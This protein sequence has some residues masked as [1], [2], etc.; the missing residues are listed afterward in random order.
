MKLTNNTN[1]SSSTYNKEL[2]NLKSQINALDQYVRDVDGKTD[3]LA[4]EDIS[5][6]NRINSNESSISSLSSVVETNKHEFD[7]KEAHNDQIH[8]TYDNILGIN[9]DGT[10]TTITS[11]EF[12]AINTSV[13]PKPVDIIKLNDKEGTYSPISF[14]RS[15]YNQI[16]NSIEPGFTTVFNSVV[17]PQFYNAIASGS[18][19]V[20]F[21]N[22]VLASFSG[23]QLYNTQSVS[24]PGFGSFELMFHNDGDLVTY[25]IYSKD[26]NYFEDS[27]LDIDYTI[28]YN[29]LFDGVKL[30]YQQDMTS[31]TNKLPSCDFIEIKDYC[32]INAHK[33]FTCS[34]F[35]FDSNT[36]TLE[37][38]NISYVK[39]ISIYKSKQ[40]VNDISLSSTLDGKLLNANLKYTNGYDNNKYTIPIDS[41]ELNKTGFTGIVLEGAGPQTNIRITRLGNEYTLSIL[42]SDIEPYLIYNLSFSGNVESILESNTLS[43]NG[44]S[45]SNDIIAKATETYPDDYKM[46]D[47][48]QRSISVMEAHID[49]LSNDT[50]ITF[51]DNVNT[52]IR[53]MYDDI[54]NIKTGTSPLIDYDLNAEEHTVSLGINDFPTITLSN[55]DGNAIK[56]NLPKSIINIAGLPTTISTTEPVYRIY[57]DVNIDK[58]PLSH[59]QTTVSTNGIT[60]VA[61]ALEG[62]TK[63]I[64]IKYGNNFT[65]I[66]IVSTGTTE[67]VWN[68]TNGTITLSSSV[69]EH[70][71][72]HVRFIYLVVNKQFN[73]EINLDVYCIYTG[74][75]KAYNITT[76]SNYLGDVIQTLTF[77]PTKENI[78]LTL[79]NQEPYLFVSI[80]GEIHKV[81]HSY[82][83]DNPPVS[84]WLFSGGDNPLMMYSAFVGNT[85]AIYPVDSRLFPNTY[86]VKIYKPGELIV[87]EDKNP[88]VSERTKDCYYYKQGNDWFTDRSFTNEIK[89][90]QGSD[91]NVVLYYPN[92]NKYLSDGACVAAKLG[93]NVSSDETILFN[94]V[95][96]TQ[97]TFGGGSPVN[98]VNVYSRSNNIPVILRRLD[99]IEIRLEKIEDTLARNLLY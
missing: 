62:E 51:K 33:D 16:F 53:S 21:N 4:S 7:T 96:N 64:Y 41:D 97:V 2:D 94:Y 88:D 24:I 14:R 31:I 57:K 23:E 92:T 99:D 18:I 47:A 45:L 19:Q 44:L 80:N 58:L 87:E 50:N 54:Q 15:Y 26:G 49:H 81:Y 68:T 76:D 95:S 63:S 83:Y 11:N 48:K 82:D 86:E 79:N 90:Y 27:K 89:L 71:E 40:Y 30:S 39:E 84:Y 56:A 77:E 17:N 74:D 12:K 36:N 70:A 52:S 98:V 43:G 78:E 20:A 8:N 25:S 59:I 61:V 9:R 55:T 67:T 73:E 34:L 5:I 75:I 28:Q 66:P 72:Q 35:E 60:K 37:F 42:R 93:L 22:T 6:N 13:T 38:H 91:N 69:E 85:F 1:K 32:V 3:N 46:L 10:Y 65:S 29:K